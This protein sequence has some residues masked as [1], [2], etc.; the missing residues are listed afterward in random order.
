MSG[1]ADN[2]TQ[3]RRVLPDALAAYR[4]I[5]LLGHVNYALYLSPSFLSFS[6]IYRDNPHSV[7][8]C[9]RARLLSP[10]CQIKSKGSFC[11][12]IP[13]GECHS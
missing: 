8:L 13:V 11:F 1:L 12:M 2:N 7:S 10:H 9:P 3:T 4:M 5:I 6:S